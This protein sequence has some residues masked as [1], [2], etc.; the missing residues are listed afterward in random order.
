MA[1]L[2][3]TR[4]EE[5]QAHLG[6]VHQF[7]GHSALVGKDPVSIGCCEDDVIFKRLIPAN[8]SLSQYVGGEAGGWR[9]TLHLSGVRHCLGSPVHSYV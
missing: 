7:T 3:V 2:K 5:T 8:A 6:M 4:L 1:Q 9:I